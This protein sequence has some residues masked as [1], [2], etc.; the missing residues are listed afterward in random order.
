[1][2][3]GDSF[4][5]SLV[6]SVQGK[7]ILRG[8]FTP[9]LSIPPIEV[10]TGG[11]KSLAPLKV[12]YVYHDVVFKERCNNSPSSSFPGDVNRSRL[13]Y[14]TYGHKSRRAGQVGLSGDKARCVLSSLRTSTIN[15]AH[16]TDHNLFNL[17]SRKR[18]TL[19][20]RSVESGISGN[21]E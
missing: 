15:V 16:G 3:N 18:S 13:I 20:H 4:R 9:H 2:Y 1:M 8:R 12:K 19:R 5:K 17:F 7:R 6:G 21:T 10:P 11:Y 14:G